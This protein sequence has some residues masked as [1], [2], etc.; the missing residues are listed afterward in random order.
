MV[1]LSYATLTTLALVGAEGLAVPTA[2]ALGG[3]G[4]TAGVLTA[5]LPAGFLIGSVLILRIPE[6][7]RDALLTPLTA[8]V[9]APLLL[10]PVVHSTAVLATLWTLA[11]IASASQIIS[12]ASYVMATPAHARGR[13]FGVAATVMLG[14]QGIALLLLGWLAE[15]VDPRTAVALTAGAVLVL[16]LPVRLCDG[17]TG[18]HIAGRN[19]AEAARDVDLSQEVERPVRVPQG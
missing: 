6:E 14:V 4:P 16:L 11:G 12:N 13:A 5:T 1:L 7:K 9:C 15:V 8:L 17:P 3:G 19:R 18:R 2:D 10:S